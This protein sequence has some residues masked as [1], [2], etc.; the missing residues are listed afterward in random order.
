MFIGILV[1]MSCL[2]LGFNSHGYFLWLCNCTGFHSFV[3]CCLPNDILLL[4]ILSLFSILIDCSFH[5]CCPCAHCFSH[6]CS[7][8]CSLLQLLSEFGYQALDSKLLFGSC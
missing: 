5:S 1:A 7:V 2:F 4:V 3:L 6:H 8:A